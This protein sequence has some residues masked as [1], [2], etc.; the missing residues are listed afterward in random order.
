ML[1]Y[2][3]MGIPFI[4]FVLLL[5]MVIL[6]TWVI[7]QHRTWLIMAVLLVFTSL[8][9]QLLVIYIVNYNEAHMLGLRLGRAPIEDFSYT[10]A[11][12]IGISAMLQHLSKTEKD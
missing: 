1:T 7:R 3:L 5:D 10:I 6:R 9:D 11:A 12:V 4:G 2:T 8:F